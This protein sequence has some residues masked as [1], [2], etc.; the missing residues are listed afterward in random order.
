ML[1][2]VAHARRYNRRL[3][4][5]WSDLM[6]GGAKNNAGGFAAYMTL[7]GV[8]TAQHPPPHTTSVVP[9]YWAEHPGNWNRRVGEW[10]CG[11][12]SPSFDIDMSVDHPEDIVICVN[13]NDRTW[14]IAD[15]TRHVRFT[16]P[17]E[18]T[19]H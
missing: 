8:E 9:P 17:R 15:M 1:Q 6:W 19:R 4:V 13:C 2:C 5:E 11:G 12:V 10:I 3:V 7:R 18:T 14:D 16:P